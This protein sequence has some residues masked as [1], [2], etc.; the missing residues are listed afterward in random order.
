ML[1]IV[2]NLF[3]M[4]KM[5]QLMWINGL[6]QLFSRSF[7]CSFSFISVN[8]IKIFCFWKKLS[9]HFLCKT[10]VVWFSYKHCARFCAI[11]GFSWL[12]RGFVVNFF[13]VLPHFMTFYVILFVFDGFSLL[14]QAFE[15]SIKQS[16]VEDNKWSAEQT[17]LC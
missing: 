17:V 13:Q 10:L 3:K 1:K 2:Q 16:K 7:V 5:L 6:C 12:G 11:F 8:A 15:F 14:V 4:F 9:S